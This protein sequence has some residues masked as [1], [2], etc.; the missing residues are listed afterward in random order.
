MSDWREQIIRQ[1]ME[2]CRHFTGVQNEKCR[3]GLAYPQG[4][5]AQ[6]IPCLPNLARDRELLQCPKFEVM[7]REEAEV[8]ADAQ[9]GAMAVTTAARK[10]AKADAKEKG[11]GRGKGGAGSLPCPK[12]PGRIRYTVASLNGHMWGCCTTKGCVSWME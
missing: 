7:N 8:I 6:A 10:A 3:A 2:S 4:N 9:L 12:C 1:E 11:L 5:M